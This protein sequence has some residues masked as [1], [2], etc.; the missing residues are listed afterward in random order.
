M[1]YL[2]L[3]WLLAPLAILRCWLSPASREPASILIIQT[4]KIGDYICTTPLIRAL[5]D[6]YPAARLSLLVQE[7]V[8]PLASCQPGV[9]KVFVMKG[10]APKGFAGRWALYR[11]LRAE[12]VDTT[13][14]FSPNQAYLLL[15]FLAGTTR[16]TSILPNYGGRSYRLAAPFLTHGEPHRQGRMTVETGL[17]LLARLGVPV[18]LPPKEI[19]LAPGAANRVSQHVGE[20]SGE[21]LGL[22]ISSGNKLKELGNERLVALARRLLDISGSITLVLV[23]S[24]ADRDQARVVVDALPAGRVIDTTGLIALG[25]LAALMDRLH[26]YVGVDSGITYLADARGTPVIDIMGPA[27]PEDQRPTGKRAI[28]I[29]ATVNC[30]PCSHA[31]LAPYTCA[32]GTRACINE[33]PDEQVVTAARKVL[34]S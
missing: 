4:A 24:R 5:R 10:G 30:A 16:R 18:Q 27:D 1:S 7:M 13:V 19:G 25:D 8:E 22:G 6:R 11:L 20:A 17:M 23:G 2:I 33:T 3:T 15:P 28:V 34:N 12:R 21:L 29:G 31:F 14:C 26:L 9:D 32:I